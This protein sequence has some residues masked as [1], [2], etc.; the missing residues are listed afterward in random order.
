MSQQ[1]YAKAL[2]RLKGKTLETLGQ[3]QKRR[4]DEQ[5]PSIPTTHIA[6][7]NTDDTTDRQIQ[8]MQ[9]KLAAIAAAFQRIKKRTFGLCE[10][11]GE[12]IDPERLEASPHAPLCITCQQSL[13]KNGRRHIAP[14]CRQGPSKR[15]GNP[16]SGRAHC[17]SVGR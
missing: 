11:C 14:G 10:K 4:A 2:R 5:P 12:Q 16:V 13:E 6:D 3:L 17:T 8:C 9:D 15:N 1:E 7:T